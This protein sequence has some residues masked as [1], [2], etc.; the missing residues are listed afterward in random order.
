MEKC[1]AVVVGGGPAGATCARSL[2]AAGFDVVVLDRARFPREKPCAGW[3]TPNVF[4]RLDLDPAEYASGRTLQPLAGFLVGTVGGR[5]VETRYGGI[6]GYAVRRAE[7]DDLL[8]RRSGARL[9][10]GEAL[11]RLERSA[12]RWVANGNVAAPVLV[13]AGGHFCP[14]GRLLGAERRGEVVVAQVAEVEL[15]AA[16]AR[17]CP[18]A[19]DTPELYFSPDLRGYGWCL[20][21]GPYLNVGLGRIGGKDLRAQVEAFLGRLERIGRL[22]RGLRLPLRGHAYGLRSGPVAP[23]V[24]EGLL[25]VGDAACLADPRSGEGLGPAV[26]SGLLAGA[27]IVAAAGDYRAEA[28]TLGSPAGR[29]GPAALRFRLPVPLRGFLGRRL[30][31]TSW[32]TRRVVLDRWFLHGPPAVG[33]R[34]R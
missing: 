10:L 20:R 9:R 30:L 21:K 25:R 23:V 18:V 8:L 11:T 34:E 2:V 31:A 22:P 6:V 5:A 1:D 3:V 16:E 12:G 19:P 17:T 14:V 33:G 32:F 27:R 28:L 13:A 7:F 15:T 4:R 29:C 26:E 24:G